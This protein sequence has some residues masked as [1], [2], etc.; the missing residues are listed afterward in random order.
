[1]VKTGSRVT[2]RRIKN[3]DEG[4]QMVHNWV[5]TLYERKET[6]GVYIEC[7]KHAQPTKDTRRGLV[8][9]EIGETEHWTL[10]LSIQDELPEGTGD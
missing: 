4:R 2:E 9:G 8:R 5:C 10:R 7:V 3:C 6:R 1:M